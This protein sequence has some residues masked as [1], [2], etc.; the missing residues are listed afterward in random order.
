[1]DPARIVAESLTPRP[2][3]REQHR[4]ISAVVETHERVLQ[5][6]PEA[7]VPCVISNVIRGRIGTGEAGRQ[8][9]SF[10]RPSNIVS[11]RAVHGARRGTEPPA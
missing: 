7:E 6:L 8:V 4:P 1:M 9:P 2:G 10:M 3:I 5:H 11:T